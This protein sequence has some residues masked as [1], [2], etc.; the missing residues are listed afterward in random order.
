MGELFDEDKAVREFVDALLVKRALTDTEREQYL[1]IEQEVS[2]KSLAYYSL[3]K[4]DREDTNPDLRIEKEKMLRAKTAIV[5]YAA[6][7]EGA[8]ELT[9]EADRQIAFR[10]EKPLFKE[11]VFNAL[12]SLKH[13]LR[14]AKSYIFRTYIIQERNYRDL[15]RLRDEKGKDPAQELDRLKQDVVVPY[16]LSAGLTAIAGCFFF[17]GIIADKQPLGMIVALIAAAI[18]GVVTF[19]GYS[20]WRIIR[21]TQNKYQEIVDGDQIEALH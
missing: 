7:L 5:R 6:G 12:V 8:Q 16:L 1:A 20:N 3:Q 17:I 19:A 4:K 18:I 11:R 2:E 9:Q 13:S 10:T 15:Q 21:N 14:N